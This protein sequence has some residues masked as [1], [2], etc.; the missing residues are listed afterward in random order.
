MAT[1]V[2][3]STRPEI[4]APAGTEMLAADSSGLKKITSQTLVGKTPFAAT[5]D[6]TQRTAADHISNLTGLIIAMGA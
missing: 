4:I 6:S 1:E 3:L 2:P 5:G